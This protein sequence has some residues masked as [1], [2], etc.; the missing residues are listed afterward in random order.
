MSPK[1]S[2]FPVFFFLLLFAVSQ[3]SAQPAK[4]RPIAYSGI[5][6]KYTVRASAE[7]ME[8][9]VEDPIVLRVQVEGKGPKDKEPDR[10]C[11]DHSRKIW[12]KQFYVLDLKDEDEINRAKGIWTFVF[13]LKP[14]HSRIDRIDDIM[15]AF[16][17]PESRDQ[18]KYVTDYADPIPIKVKPRPDKS[19]DAKIEAV[20]AP[21]SFFEIADQNRVLKPSGD[22]AVSQWF[23]IVV[24]ILGPLG[25]F[26]GVFAWRNLVP[27]EVERARR[28]R[29][30]AAPRALARLH[31]HADRIGDAM[32]QYLCERFDYPA[33]DVMPREAA[34]F[35]KR[36]GFA[37]PVCERVRSFFQSADLERY[38][39]SEDGHARPTAEDAIRL[40]QAL[41]ADPCARA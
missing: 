24:I 8:V 6:G 22:F 10:H 33:S 14:K 28:H 18:N 36:R 39:E 13:R 5:V 16:Y 20:A 29:N 30:N 34:A 19:G 21:A 4:D 9:Q 1:Y 12:E 37:L 2:L 11:L 38:A 25:C 31:S 35:L 7:P 15:I 40:I 27:D 17:D 32:R 41:E 23:V 3:V 26:A